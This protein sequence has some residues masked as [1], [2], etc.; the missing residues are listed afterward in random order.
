VWAVGERGSNVNNLLDHVISG[1]INDPSS[2]D[3]IHGIMNQ[4]KILPN[5]PQLTF[6]PLLESLKEG[7]GCGLTGRRHVA[8]SLL[9]LCCGKMRFE[10]GNIWTAI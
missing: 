9:A 6:N 3:C 8:K 5:T 10:N 4:I 2:E 7:F 1:I